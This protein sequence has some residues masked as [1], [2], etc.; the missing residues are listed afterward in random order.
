MLKRSKKLLS[1]LVSGMMALQLAAVVP[2]SA[3][4]DEEVNPNLVVNGSFENGSDGWARKTF[5]IF[6]RSAN[7][8]DSYA[9]DSFMQLWGAGSF[10]WQAIDVEPNTNYTLSFAYKN[11]YSV[12]DYG[13]P[14]RFRIV[15][16]N[17]KGINDVG[18]P[19]DGDSLIS[20]PDG[21]QNKPGK[22][23][24][25][26]EKWV[27]VHETFNTGNNSKIYLVAIHDYTYSDKL[28]S[29]FV[30]SFELRKTPLI[31]N[32]GF[33]YN[34]TGWTCLAFN[35]LDKYANGADVYEGE[36]CIQ[37][38]NADSV[39]Y[40]KITVKP[41]TEY[42]ISLAYKNAFTENKS[43]KLRVMMCD[44]N[45][46]DQTTGNPNDGISLIGD[47]IG[48]DVTKAGKLYDTKSEW[49]E[50]AEY[51]N[52]GDNSEV[53]LVIQHDRTYGYWINEA[54]QVPYPGMFVDNI[55]LNEAPL[56]KNG[57]FEYGKDHWNTIA[58]NV[59]NDTQATPNTGSKC[60]YLWN[61]GSYIYQAVNVE[62]NTE[63]S[64]NFAYKQDSTDKSNP[65]R[66][67]IAGE[68]G[69]DKDGTPND[70]MSI[71][72][73]NKSK[74]ESGNEIKS[75]KLY[76]INAEWTNVN[77]VFNTGNNSVIYLV[78]KNEYGLYENSNPYVDSF[79]LTKLGYIEPEI[80]VTNATAVKTD[81]TL[82]VS[83]VLYNSKI[84]DTLTTAA[85]AAVYDSN[86]KLIKASLENVDLEYLHQTDFNTSI[87]LDEE[88]DTTGYTAA[89]YLWNRTTNMPYLAKTPVTLNYKD[90]NIGD[91]RKRQ[92]LR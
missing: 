13:R 41:N 63:Y 79:E 43:N 29:P 2:A 50:I 7:Q 18:N 61:A 54:N 77:E 57:G 56:L 38:W 78:V 60:A 32:G 31:S 26:S 9:G 74:D 39:T 19:V 66:I 23:Y 22:L 81:N 62:K 14:N 8:G 37:L 65:L 84:N 6:K 89:I 4:V 34:Y 51:F 85:I 27:D 20:A 87:T 40:Q 36:K 83:A 68:A 59:L 30:D 16:A 69:I 28:P 47:S 75:G 64:L 10:D 52:S 3:A 88:T 24:D 80:T 45:G 12:T 21:M 86:G 25:A 33:E 49:T 44:S 11:D 53:T 90:L 5:E 55:E 17:E 82:N 15:I 1:A 46:F 35:P 72:G 67:T 42:E 92:S 76:P 48:G 70:G 73:V 71:I 91:C 58:Y